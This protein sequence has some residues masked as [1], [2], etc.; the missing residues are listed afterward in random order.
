[1]NREAVQKEINRIV[2][3]NRNNI[4]GRASRN[5]YKIAKHQEI[6]LRELGLLEMMPNAPYAQHS[7]HSDA[8]AVIEAAQDSG[9]EYGG[10][11]HEDAGRMSA[12]E[13]YKLLT[14]EEVPVL[15]AITFPVTHS[16]PMEL[17]ILIREREILSGHMKRR[18]F[19]I[20]K[21]K[22][23][24]DDIS[25][26]AIEMDY[27]IRVLTAHVNAEKTATTK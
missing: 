13:L 1:M 22:I 9:K 24:E 8:K 2:E 26:D 6:T 21:N 4:G 25:M 18:A 12:S 14:E 17:A 10:F 11:G 19:G 16:L 23:A 15:P 7:G 5:Q 20:R 27:R 3:E